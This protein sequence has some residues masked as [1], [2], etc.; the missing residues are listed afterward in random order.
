MIK[1]IIV[2]YVINY[3]N[4]KC[5]SLY[6]YN[7]NQSRGHGKSLHTGCPLNSR[8][9]LPERANHSYQHKKQM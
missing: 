7:L 2:K 6:I 1:L 4:N 9:D 5:L 8:F 3:F